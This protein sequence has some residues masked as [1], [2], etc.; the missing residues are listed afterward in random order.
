MFPTEKVSSC[1]HINKNAHQ[2]YLKSDKWTN[3]K[4]LYL[5]FEG[6]IE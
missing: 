3:T 2:R 4:N 5:K 6:R 1:H